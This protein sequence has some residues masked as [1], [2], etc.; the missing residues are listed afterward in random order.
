MQ[1]IVTDFL[2][3]IGQDHIGI[4]QLLENVHC[5][6]LSVSD[7]KQYGET[8]FRKMCDVTHSLLVIGYDCLLSSIHCH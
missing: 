5:H 1:L 6:S 7:G 2:M 8:A 4:R 3:V